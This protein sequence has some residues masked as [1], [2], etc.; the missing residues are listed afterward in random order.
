MR[1]CR[2]KLLRQQINGG[3]ATLNIQRQNVWLGV[4]NFTQLTQIGYFLLIHTQDH[5]A[6]F[7]PMRAAVEPGFTSSTFT[8][9]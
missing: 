3:I 9:F 7:R 5:V 1:S 8:P 4:E 6:F 2:R